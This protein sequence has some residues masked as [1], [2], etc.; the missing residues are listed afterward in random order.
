MRALFAEARIEERLMAGELR[1]EERRGTRHAAPAHLAEP[2]GTISHAV[3]YL[4]ADG[5][6]QAIAHEY[7]RPDGSIGASGLRDPKWIRHEGVSYKLKRV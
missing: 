1:L 7:V 2:P 4:A 3:V 5:V 6:A